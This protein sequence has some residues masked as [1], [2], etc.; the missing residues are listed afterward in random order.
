[1]NDF[2]AHNGKAY[3]LAGPE[4][5]TGNEIVELIEYAAGVKVEKV[6]FR[7]TEFLE[8]LGT[9]GIIPFK[10]LADLLPISTF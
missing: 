6:E 7:N 10:V 2:S 3:I 5:V 1:L 9:Q 8:D 4:D